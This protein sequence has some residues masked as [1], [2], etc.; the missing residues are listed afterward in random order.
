MQ[1]PFRM[2][3]LSYTSGLGCDAKGEILIFTRSRVSLR[4]LKR[5]EVVKAKC[6]GCL[7]RGFR[8]WPEVYEEDPV[9]AAPNTTLLNLHHLNLRTLPY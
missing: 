6:A 5:P 4:S 2:L 7:A 3:K 9:D 1:T 8:V